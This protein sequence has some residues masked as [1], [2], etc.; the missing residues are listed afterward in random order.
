MHWPERSLDL[1]FRGRQ[2]FHPGTKVHT[3]RLHTAASSRT[4][5]TSGTMPATGDNQPEVKQECFPT[6]DR[7]RGRGGERAQ[8]PGTERLAMLSIYTCRAEH[9]SLEDVRQGDDALY[10][11]AL[12]HH[13]QPM[14]LE[15]NNRGMNLISVKGYFQVAKCLYPSLCLKKISLQLWLFCPQW[16]PSSPFCGTSWLL[17]STESDV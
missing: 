1:F 17:R 8:G 6:R 16:S 3:T 9:Q 11:G 15:Q 7:V 13:H 14:H 12:V 4:N 10:A 5:R 2:P